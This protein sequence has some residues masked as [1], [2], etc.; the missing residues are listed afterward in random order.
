MARGNT[1][2]VSA[3]PK[4]VFMEG[5]VS[6]TP[7]PGTIM[8]IS[9]FTMVG[10]RFTWRAYQPGT[11]GERRLIAVLLEDNLQGKTPTDAYV[12]G[13]RC[14]LYCPIAGE[15]LNCLLADVAGTG[16][17]HTAGETLIVDTGTGKLIA[18]TGS[19]ESEP[20]RLL[21]SLSALTA[22]TLAHVMYTGQ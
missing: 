6:G 1:I 16:D 13:T 14:F 15:E 10:G 22:D 18:T 11:D 20:F 19:P 2:I 8:E 5:V 4:G 7:K 17:A 3:D 12:D 9:S 21:E